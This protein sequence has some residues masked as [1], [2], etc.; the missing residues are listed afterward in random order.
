MWDILRAGLLV[1]FA[2]FV[3]SFPARNVDVWLHLATGR[4]LVQGDYHLGADPFSYTT[5]GSVWV[6]H[7]WLFDAASYGVYSAFAGAGLVAGKALLIA[8][9]AVW[10][11]RPCW[12]GPYR[13][14]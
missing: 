7:A 8:L 9:L 6:N 1:T 2:F 4:A 3:A 11:L 12:S 13:W 10:L 14:L 5:A